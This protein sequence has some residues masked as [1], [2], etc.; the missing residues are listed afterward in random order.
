MPPLVSRGGEIVHF[1]LRPLV[2]ELKNVRKQCMEIEGEYQEKKG[3]H[4]KVQRGGG[5]GAVAKTGKVENRLVNAVHERARNET[6]SVLAK[7][8]AP[9]T[10]I[11]TSFKIYSPRTL[12][13]ERLRFQRPPAP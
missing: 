1:S 11:G 5:G 10:S 9:E 2:E 8:A 4:E 13:V 12:F 3:S 7:H 6:L